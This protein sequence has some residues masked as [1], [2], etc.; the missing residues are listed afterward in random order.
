MCEVC[1]VHILPGNSFEGT[2]IDI[3]PDFKLLIQKTRAVIKMGISFPNSHKI[4]QAQPRTRNAQAPKVWPAAINTT[5]ATRST[6]FLHMDFNPLLHS[7][8]CFS[9]KL[10]HCAGN[11]WRDGDRV[12]AR[13]KN[14]VWHIVGWKEITVALRGQIDCSLRK[15]QQIFFK[16]LKRCTK[17]NKSW[18]KHN[19][20]S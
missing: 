18:I 2:V 6:G 17:H 14:G 12:T 7:S 10:S 5:R 3:K 19:R 4:N 15:T 11:R 16:M 8:C 1:C 13:G 20:N 9:S